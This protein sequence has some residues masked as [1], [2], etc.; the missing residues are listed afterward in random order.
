MSV[1]C[2]DS[3]PEIHVFSLLSNGERTKSPKREIVDFVETGST[4]STNLLLGTD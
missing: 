2:R 4:G 3:V 1:I